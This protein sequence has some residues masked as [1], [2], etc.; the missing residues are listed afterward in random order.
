MLFRS[1]SVREATLTWRS[2]VGVREDGSLIYAAGPSLSASALA[3]A[4]VAAGVQRAMVLDMNN[5]WTA[6]FY[7]R[8]KADGTPVCRKLDPQIPEGCDR[9]LNRYKRDSFQVLARQP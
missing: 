7:F 3:D 4:L 1:P 5:W 8:H 6:G 2:A 9:F